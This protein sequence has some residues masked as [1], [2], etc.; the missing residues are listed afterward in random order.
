MERHYSIQR[1]FPAVSLKNS[2]QVSNKVWLLL[3]VCVTENRN[4]CKGT[5]VRFSQTGSTGQRKQIPVIDHFCENNSFRI[6]CLDGNF[7][8][9]RHNGKHSQ[10]AFVI[11]LKYALFGAKYVSHSWPDMQFCRDLG[12]LGKHN[13]NST[14]TLVPRVRRVVQLCD[15][16]TAEVAWQLDKGNEPWSCNQVLTLTNSVKT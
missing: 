8:T 11:C 14:F 5:A 9:I 7:Q 10:Y 6:E 12:T 1:N 3:R 2:I 16:M 13:K 15:Y 4:L